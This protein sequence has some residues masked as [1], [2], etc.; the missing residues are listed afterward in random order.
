IDPH[1]LTFNWRKKIS[2][3]PNLGNV[4]DK[5]LAPKPSDRYSTVSQVIAALEN[6]ASST[7]LAPTQAA[8]NVISTPPI[9]ADQISNVTT[10]PVSRIPV[11]TNKT[12]KFSIL[13]TILLVLITIFSMGGIGWVAGNLWLEYKSNQ[14]DKI[15]NEKPKELSDRLKKSG[16]EESF[17]F[18]LVDDFFYAKYPQKKG[19]TLSDESSEDKL[20]KWRWY[21]I[22]NQLLNKLETLSLDARRRL[23]NYSKDD[24]YR[25]KSQLSRLNISSAAFNDL[26]D[27][28]FFYLFSEQPRGKNII[29]LPMGQIWQAIATDTMKALQSRKSLEEISFTRGSFR[30]VVNGNLEPGEGKIYL[31]WIQ[32]DQFLR[33]RLRANSP[34][35][36]LSIYSPEKYRGSS[37]VLVED[38]NINRWRGKTLTSGYYQFVVVSNSDQPIEYFLG[39]GARDRINSRY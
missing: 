31:A 30:E 7:D 27:A 28:K 9:T 34:E 16:I 38:R 29:G 10:T 11:T 37:R 19:Q 3:S 23:G 18:P 4:L 8:P 39:I 33:I 35:V 2:I 6:V 32:A 1:N 26:T 25:W 17:F 22:A 21:E 14:K 20:W 15:V 13:S 24:I 12:Q 5:M 36:F